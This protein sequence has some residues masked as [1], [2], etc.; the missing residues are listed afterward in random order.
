M[1]KHVRESQGRLKESSAYWG[2]M[3]G[4]GKDAWGGPGERAASGR[5]TG[6]TGRPLD[7]PLK[8]HC[9]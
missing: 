2:Q 4:Q 8:S 7:C 3:Q 1:G 6:G 5:G 9:S